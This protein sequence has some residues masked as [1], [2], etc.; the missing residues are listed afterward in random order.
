MHDLLSVLRSLLLFVIA[1]LCEIGGGWLMWKWL[2]DGRPGWWGLLGGLI[3]VGYGVIPTLQACHFGR[4]Y[5]VYGGF[6][7][8]LSLLWGWQADGNRPDWG[9]MVGAAIAI[10]GVCVMMYSPRPQGP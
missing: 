3:L 5:A 7:I 1:G 10:A 2:R 8:V 4:V 6:F 9:D